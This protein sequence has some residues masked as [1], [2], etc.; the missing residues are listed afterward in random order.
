MKGQTRAGEGRK[1]EKG[2]GS[3]GKNEEEKGRRGEER[4]KKRENQRLYDMDSCG[5]KILTDYLREFYF[6]Y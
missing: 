4:K 6:L 5:Y 3:E 2:K 1:G